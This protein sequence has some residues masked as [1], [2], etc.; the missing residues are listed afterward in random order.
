MLEQ[1]AGGE[2]SATGAKKAPIASRHRFFRL[3]CVKFFKTVTILLTGW[4]V[5][6]SEQA[7]WCSVGKE[8]GMDADFWLIRKMKAGDEAAMD[9]FVRSH[10]AAVLKYCRYHA[11]D[12][13]KAEDLAQETFM[14][15][16]GALSGYRHSG[17][18][19]N[20]LYR[21]ARNLCIDS[22][23]KAREIP[24]DKIREEEPWA[25]G[26]EGEREW[27]IDLENALNSLPLELQEIVILHY[28]QERTLKETAAILGI[29]LPLA[30]YRCKRALELL[31]RQ[32]GEE[33]KS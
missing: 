33:D 21:I 17:K 4:D 6:H 24:F 25:L 8:S 3:N 14:R 1:K 18:A 11:P 19:V 15:F 27:G 29:G 5:M 12:R 22:G 31:R 9:L 2:R 28:F 20:Y 30:K 13:Q 23:K 10:Y 32:M 7:E 16:F 26:E